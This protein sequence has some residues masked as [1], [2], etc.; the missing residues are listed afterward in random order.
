M[1]GERGESRREVSTFGLSLAP[2]RETA[3]RPGPRL[4]HPGGLRHLQPRP[5][6]T[7][8]GPYPRAVGE[9]GALTAGGPGVRVRRRAR[10]GKR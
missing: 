1:Q 3:K 4:R 6:A 7:A 9:S 2:Q 10:G 8:G 5:G